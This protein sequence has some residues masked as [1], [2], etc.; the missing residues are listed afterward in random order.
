M[1]C[2]LSLMIAWTMIY[3]FLQS[4][5]SSIFVRTIYRG[6]CDGNFYGPHTGTRTQLVCLLYPRV[7]KTTQGGT[8]KPQTP[9][10][11]IPW[12]KSPL[13]KNST[14]EA[15]IEPGTSWLIGNNV[16]PEP[17]DRTIPTIKEGNLR[18]NHR[19]QQRLN[20]FP[21][22]LVIV[23]WHDSNSTHRLKCRHILDL[24]YR[25]VIQWRVVYI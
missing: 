15:E 14:K 18:Y 5:S 21:N 1:F 2:G 4:F 9:S 8:M 16:T 23:F 11:C 10:L 17:S 24:S 6:V 7:K 3:S 19:Y 22:Y 25:F 13:E 12:K 20:K